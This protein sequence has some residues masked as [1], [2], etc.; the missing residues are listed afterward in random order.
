MLAKPMSGV[1]YSLKKP[2]ENLLENYPVDNFSIINDECPRKIK[3]LDL[4]F[5]KG[6][7]PAVNL[8]FRHYCAASSASAFAGIA[9]AL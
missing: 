9:G 4:F 5:H 7:N 2:A 1:D 8:L 6:C 3:P